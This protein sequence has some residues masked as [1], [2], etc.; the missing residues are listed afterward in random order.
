MKLL[1]KTFI[2]AALACSFAGLASCD[3]F[4]DKAPENKVPEQSVDYTNLSNMYQPVSGVYAQLRNGGMHWISC[5]AFLVRDDDIWSGRQDDQAD[6]ISIGENFVYNSAWWG[7]DTTWN[8]YYAIIRYANSALNDL[9]QFEKY[10]TTDI[11]KERCNSYKGEVHVLRAYAYYRLAQ[12]FGDI[13]IYRDNNQTDMTR[14]KRDVVFNYVLNEDLKY[15]MENLPRVHPA[16]MEHK[17]AVTAFTAEMLAAKIYLLMGKYDRVESLTDDIIA[18]NKFALYP[19]FYNLFKMSGRLC[20]ESLFEVQTTNFGLGS[21]D[22]I[23]AGDFFTFQGPAN[24]G[25]ISGW[26]FIGYRDQFV[27]WAKQ[28]GETVRANTTFLKGGEVTLSGDTIKGT[29][30]PTATNCWNGKVYLPKSETIDG[31]NYGSGNN[32][33]LMRYAEVLLMNAE[34][35]VRLGKNGDAGFNEVR[36][37]AHMPE[38]TNVTLDDILD[39]RRMELAGEWGERYS[40][41]VRTGEAARVLNE[42]TDPN[43]SDNYIITNGWTEDKTYYPVPLEQITNAPS[44]ENPPLDE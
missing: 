27:E 4:L 8:N 40:D 13:T 24:T 19:D 26:G 18:S 2:Y 21:G 16:E 15:A 36:R 3:D 37:R 43:P 11:D 5:A 44:L 25:V 31:R 29:Q 34:A 12:L 22:E 9:D 6:L 7:F 10:A 32:I 23:T 20:S 1:N 30:N 42:G 39:E 35:K 41:L 38:K 33:R 14:S 17:G 28:R